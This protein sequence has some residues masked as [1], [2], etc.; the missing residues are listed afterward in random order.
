MSSL[1][2][3]FQKECAILITHSRNLV[4]LED[5]I[6][7]LLGQKIFQIQ[8]SNRQDIMDEIPRKTEQHLCHPI[9]PSI[10]WIMSDIADSLPEEVNLSTL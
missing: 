10:M 9:N 7:N 4:M 1:S 3:I 8:D 5:L 6:L 2:V